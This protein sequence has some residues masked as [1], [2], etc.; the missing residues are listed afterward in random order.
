MK[1]SMNL[2]R[3]L[4]FIVNAKLFSKYVTLGN[5]IDK[6]YTILGY[7]AFRKSFLKVFNIKKKL[8]VKKSSFRLIQL[9]QIR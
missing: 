1:T 3:E 7:L 6:K 2:Y 4:C 9:V 5:S 8:D